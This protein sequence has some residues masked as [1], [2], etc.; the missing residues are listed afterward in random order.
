MRIFAVAAR[1]ITVH[2]SHAVVMDFL[3]RIARTDGTRVS[4]ARIGAGG[5][6]GV[7]RGQIF[8]VV[9]GRGEV[10]AGGGPRR[11][12]EAGQAAV[13]EPGEMHQSWASVDMLVAIVE[14]AGE[15][16]LDEHFVE[17]HD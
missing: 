10:A 15:V 12:I 5:T 3:P 14:T 13:W 6:I 11:L 9:D 16:E 17:I 7:H 8:A 2:A 4:I 1:E